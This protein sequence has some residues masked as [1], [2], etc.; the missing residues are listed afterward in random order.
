MD[1]G[2]VVTRITLHFTKG[3]PTTNV[4]PVE[5]GDFA[6]VPGFECDACHSDLRV[7][8]ALTGHSRDTYR[9]TALCFNCGHQIGTLEAQVDTIFGIDEDEAM[10]V[11]GRARVY[12]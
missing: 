4:V 1:A 7:R 9:A 5:S 10:L 2:W 11:H 12:R 3:P 8:G 6:E